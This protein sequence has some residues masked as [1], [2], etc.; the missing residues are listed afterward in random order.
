[1]FFRNLTLFRFAPTLDL[2]DLENHL[3]QAALKPV[4][5]LDLSS[6]GFIP[7]FGRDTE[8]LSHQR[9]KAIWV[10]VGSEEKLLPGAVVNDMLQKRLDDLE[11]KEGRRPGGR[12]RKRLKEDL[13]HELLPRAFVRPGRTDAIPVSYTHLRAPRDTR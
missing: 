8:A 3:S 11:Q 7:P 2:S 13:V 6:R 4:G 12:T 10:S 5:P 1:M 9:G